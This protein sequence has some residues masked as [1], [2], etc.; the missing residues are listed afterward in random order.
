LIFGPSSFAHTVSASGAPTVAVYFSAI[1]VGG[2]V[3]T[4]PSAL[5]F[6]VGGVFL[7]AASW[8]GSTT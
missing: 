5:N 4:G 7:L 3:K 6:S 8:N 2:P 1:T